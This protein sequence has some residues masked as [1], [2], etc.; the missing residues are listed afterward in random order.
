[1]TG[2]VAMDKKVECIAMLLAGGEGKRLGNLTKKIAKPAVY[3]GGKYRIID[4]PLS[5]CINSGI[6]TVGVLTQYEPLELNSHLGIG[7]PWDL[8]RM[9]GGLSIL[10]PFQEKKGG[11]WYSGTADAIY[12]NRDF[13]DR[14]DPEY[15][16]ILSG[17][18][19]YKMDYSLML[20][21]HKERNAEATISVIDVPLEEAKRFGIMHA[22]DNGVI[23]QF[24]EKPQQPTSTL[25][26]MGIYVFNW[27]FLKSYLL[28]DAGSSSSHDFGKDL[29]PAMLADKRRLFA[30]PYSGYWKDVGTVESFWEANMDL[31]NENPSLQLHDHYWRIY[32]KNHNQAPHY[33]YPDATIT[34]SLVNEGCTIKGHLHQSI[35]FH[36]V[37][38]GVNSSISQSVIMP[39]VTIGTNVSLDKVIVTEG[40]LIPDHTV[41]HSESEIIV[42]DKETINKY[43][44]AL[45][46]S[47]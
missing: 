17:D 44:T 6:E 21:Y 15:V 25:A 37:E 31:L 29:I 46:N 45:T 18:H 4:F 10:P 24:E 11:S 47:N 27:T 13:I 32:T 23:T 43:C 16:L 30:Y 42:I 9:N 40:V 26:S 20:D 1:M 36:Q 22:E 28:N 19:I 2:A 39:N 41:I 8:D 3:F 7:T 35:L 5:N 12:Q 33:L 38:I 34:N 14:H